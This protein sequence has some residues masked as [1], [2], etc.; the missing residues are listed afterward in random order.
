MC[1]SAATLALSKSPYDLQC[2]TFA[3]FRHYGQHRRLLHL[4][5]DDVTRYFRSAANQTE[6]AMSDLG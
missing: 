1:A 4:D 2:T 3:C 6:N 5:L